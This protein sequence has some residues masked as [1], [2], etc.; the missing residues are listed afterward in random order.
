MS[1]F[2][3]QVSMPTEAE[4]A[5]AAMKWYE[6]QRGTFLDELPPEVMALSA[7]THFEPFDPKAM[8]ELHSEKE[9]FSE[10]YRL[11]SAL[12]KR[13]D[14]NLHVMKTSSRSA[15]DTWDNFGFS[16]SAVQSLYW[17][18]FSERILT[19]CLQMSRVPN[20]QWHIAVREPLLSVGGIGAWEFRCFVKDGDMIAVS[21]YNYNRPNPELSLDVCI[22]VRAKLDELHAQINQ[23]MTI[24]DY[25]FDA[26]LT[27]NGMK[28]LEVNPYGL[29]D[30][31]F[32]KSYANVER[33][34]TFIQ[35]VWAIE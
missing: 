30:P 17:M 22:K 11:A 31:C 35:T 19:D 16:S 1:K 28:L 21:D 10:F 2:D 20:R 7:K 14:W 25:V 15:K 24:E 13:C 8:S 9:D 12:A 29:S 33:S 23:H 18:T 32:F 4:L 3:I 34:D 5:K 6:R 26:I 27:H